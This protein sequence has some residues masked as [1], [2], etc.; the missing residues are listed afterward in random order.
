MKKTTVLEFKLV[1]IRPYSN[2]KYGS[3]IDKIK[4]KQSY[5]KIIHLIRQQKKTAKAP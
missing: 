5:T 2:C 4:S 1:Q 3:F